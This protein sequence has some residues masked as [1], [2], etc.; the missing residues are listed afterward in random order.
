MRKSL[1][2]SL[3]VFVPHLS[4]ASL[5]WGDRLG[6]LQKQY[7][8]A[9]EHAS[10]GMSNGS[11]SHALDV[12]VLQ[13]ETIMDLPIINCRAGLYVFINSL[14]SDHCPVARTVSL[15]PSLSPGP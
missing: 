4:Q 8:L 13:L 14:V 6:M 10:N 12:S 11:G 15:Q 7:S 9:T 3:T 2:D 1:S 5:Q